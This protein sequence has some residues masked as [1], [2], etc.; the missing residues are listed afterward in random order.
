[1]LE[2]FITAVSV[3]LPLVL[4]LALGYFL[5]RLGWITKDFIRIA[6]KLNFNVF[7]PCSVFSGLYCSNFDISSGAGFL[8]VVVI[9]YITMFLIS[10]AAANLI[11]KDEAKRGTL[12]VGLFRSNTSYIGIPVACGIMGTTGSVL[13]SLMITV[14]SI[15]NNILTPISFSIHSGH[16]VTAK[17]LLRDIFGNS[18]IIMTII[19]FVLMLLHCPQFPSPVHNTIVNLGR[20]CTPLAMLCLGANLDFGKIRNDKRELLW[21]SLIRLVIYPAIGLSAAILMGFRGESLA[22]LFALYAT[23]AAT[24]LFTVSQAMGG[25]SDLGGEIVAVET[26]LSMV[27]MT[28]GIFVLKTMGLF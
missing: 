7:L 26:I 3:T 8:L 27:T 10:L 15:T 22:V 13:A 23:P 5:G 9:S 19:G 4:M 16:R 17:K 21:S 24:L 18:Y 20:V 12:A 14:G 2:N 1:M 11:S 6:N 28:I 25:D